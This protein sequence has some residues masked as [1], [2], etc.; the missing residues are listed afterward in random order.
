VQR[1]W[2]QDWWMLLRLSY[3]SPKVGGTCLD[4]LLS[5]PALDGNEILNN[6]S[7]AI[8]PLTHGTCQ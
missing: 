4:Y 3:T 2:V 6:T 1:S 5:S 7:S 8:G